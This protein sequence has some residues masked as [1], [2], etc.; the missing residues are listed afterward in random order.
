VTQQCAAAAACAVE[1]SHILA[2]RGCITVAGGPSLIAACVHAFL[3]LTAPVLWHADVTMLQVGSSQQSHVHSSLLNQ[4]PTRTLAF[5]KP[6]T[7]RAMLLL[8]IVTIKPRARSDLTQR[9]CSLCQHSSS[10]SSMLGMPFCTTNLRP[11]SGHTSAPSTSVT[12]QPASQQK[13][14]GRTMTVS[15]RQL[16]CH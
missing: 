13:A 9:G 14:K 15:F 6:G 3:A 7:L 11:V 8:R 10:F 4:L 5:S 16:P 2:C 12:C 1:L